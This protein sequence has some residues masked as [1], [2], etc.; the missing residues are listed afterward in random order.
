MRNIYFPL[1]A[2]I[3]T[4]G[5]VKCLE[6]LSKQGRVVAGVLT[7]TALLGYK[8]AV[9]PFEDRFYLVSAVS[10]GIPHTTVVPQESLDPTDNILMYDCDSLASGDGF[11]E[12]ELNAMT[13]LNLKPIH[14][15]LDNET[16]KTYSSSA[17]K[18]RVNL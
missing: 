13:S 14:I 1:T 16:S 5:H 9:L 15:R 18:Q 6:Y 17:I 3:L 12:S 2:D 10:R 7:D 11:E 8:N 4:P